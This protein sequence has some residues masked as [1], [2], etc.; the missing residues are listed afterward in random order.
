MSS[1]PPGF[2]K[3]SIQAAAVRLAAGRG[4]KGT[5]MRAIA[6]EVGVT[7]AALY[8]HYTS[9]EALYTQTYAQVIA[10]MTE[11]KRHLLESTLSFRECL[12][13][14]VRLTYDYYDRLPD[15]FTCVLLSAD[16]EAAH[17]P[18]T[19]GQGALFMELVAK[20]QQ[21]GQVRALPREVALSHFTGLMLNVPRLIQ[22]G[23]LPAPA[24]HYVDEV[25][26]AAWRVLAGAAE[27]GCA[28]P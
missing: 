3:G 25:S 5:T 14:W 15:A 22:A 8:R 18:L 9:K 13:E 28:K 26:E 1:K 19:T 27:S 16:S 2:R 17:S 7:E 4:V 12:R 11:D 24:S 23:T 6:R 10:Q 21:T 20:A